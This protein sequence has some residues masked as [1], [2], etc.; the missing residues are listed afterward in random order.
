MFIEASRSDGTGKLA[1][2]GNLGDIIKEAC[3]L[4][5]AWVKSN[6]KSLGITTI[7]TN[8]VHLHFP[9]GSVPKDG[10]SAGIATVVALVSMFLNIR[11]KP[12][13]A[14][15][16]E[17]SLSGQVL[18]VG[19]IKEKVLAAKR[20]GVCNVILPRK[21]AKDL[22]EIGLDVRDSLSFTFVGTIPE[23]LN[24]AFGM[25]DFELPILKSLL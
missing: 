13:T 11:I 3:H 7:S 8:D 17:I 2:T 5:Y 4:A 24:A 9:A 10:P 20:A 23:A 15:T 14:M 12:K 16:G 19:G 25:S 1:V 18:P 6:G 22:D 21:N